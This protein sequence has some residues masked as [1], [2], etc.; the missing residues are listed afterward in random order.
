MKRI[1]HKLTIVLRPPAE[2]TPTD[3]IVEDEAKDHEGYVVDRRRRGQVESTRKDDREI[4][5]FEELHLELLVHY[6][7]EEWGNDSEN[8]EERQT[9]VKL[10]PRENTLWSDET[11]LQ[12]QRLA[13]ETKYRK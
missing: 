2:V 6:P 3:S 8:G 1:G 4:D 12:E 7:L 10:T 5:V 13:N 9:V 11:P